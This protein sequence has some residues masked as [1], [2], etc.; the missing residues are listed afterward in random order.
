MGRDPGAA[1]SGAMPCTMHRAMTLD[2]RGRRAASRIGHPAEYIMRWAAPAARRMTAAFSHASSV[3]PEG[4]VGAAP[5]V[6]GS[7]GAWWPGRLFADGYRFAK[8][9]SESNSARAKKPPKIGHFIDC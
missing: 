6:A 9:E 3:E 4:A 8:R 5:V 1:M 7:T 2:R